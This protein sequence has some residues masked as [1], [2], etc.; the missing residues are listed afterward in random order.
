MEETKKQ[1]QVKKLRKHLLDG[2][3]VTIYS[4][5]IMK[6]KIGRLAA[7]IRDIKDDNHEFESLIK[8]KMVKINNIWCKEYA[9]SSSIWKVK[10][11]I[12]FKKI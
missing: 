5:S 3:R 9:S 4:L 12:F 10:E 1:S 7:R 6:F 2:H 11:Y 8:D